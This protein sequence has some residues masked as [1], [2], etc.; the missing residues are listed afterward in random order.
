LAAARL[1]GIAAPDVVTLRAAAVQL[2]ERIVRERTRHALARENSARIAY[3][4]APSDAQSETFRCIVDR[5]GGGRMIPM[6]KSTHLLVALGTVMAL[7]SAGYLVACSSSSS[8]PDTMQG[9]ADVTCDKY[10]QCAP[11]TLQSLWGDVATC[12]ASCASDTDA[13]CASATCP[14]GT[15]LNVAN[16]QSCKNAIQGL[17]CTDFYAGN[18]TIEADGGASLPGCDKLCQ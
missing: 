1:T 15:T 12:K 7:G 5:G 6:F 2:H 8:E 13:G 17:S 3:A 11:Q 14:S 4:L 16:L 18:P 10:S 9:L